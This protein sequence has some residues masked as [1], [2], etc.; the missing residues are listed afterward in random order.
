LPIR[1]VPLEETTP[2]PP[3]EMVIQTPVA[4]TPATTVEKKKFNPFEKLDIGKGLAVGQT[5]LGIEQLLQ[6]GHR[7]V[8]AL[9]SDFS[10]AVDRA[11]T[12]ANYGISPLER[13]IANRSIDRSR[14]A[15][16]QTIIGL[17]GG[18]AGV[19]LGN[20][21]AASISANESK[22]NLS[23]M[24]EQLRLQK[25]KYADQLIGS[26]VDM[27]RRLF[28]DKLGAFK[29]NQAAGS[30]LVGAGIRNLIGSSLYDKELA[31]QKER[32]SMYNPTFNI[33]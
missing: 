6:D 31:A 26:K 30:E 21:R 32:Q 2:A 28:E 9:D 19:A 24:S 17:S 10:K 20:I 1:Q 8:D 5:A 18:N 16:I 11:K 29:E 25:Q 22:N 3:E 12:D 33:Q 23:A 14:N 4:N 13:E 27:S 7:P 15:D